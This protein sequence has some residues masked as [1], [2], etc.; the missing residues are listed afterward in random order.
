MKTTFKIGRPKPKRTFYVCDRKK[1][2]NC[3]GMCRHTTDIQHALYTEHTEFIP[4][5]SGLWE[6]V[7]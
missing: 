4:E 5:K 2:S 7:R 3:S 6:Q 1:C